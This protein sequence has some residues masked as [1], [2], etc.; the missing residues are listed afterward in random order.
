MPQ[1]RRPPGVAAGT[2]QY[3]QQ[4]AIADHYDDFVADT[5]LCRLDSRLIL[6]LLSKQRSRENNLPGAKEVP[7]TILDLG[8]G[9]GRHSIALAA[10]GFRV[11]A[12]DL[13]QPMLQTL[14]RKLDQQATGVLVHPLR[15][16][17][18]QL[19][20]LAN[21]SADAA[22]CLFSTLGMVQ[23]QP[24]RREVLRHVARTVRAGGLFVLHVHNRWAALREPRGFRRLARSALDAWRTAEGEFG[25]A[26][27]AYRGLDEMFMHRYSRRELVADLRHSGWSI[28]QMHRVSI[29]GSRFETGARICGGFIAVCRRD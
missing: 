20:F 25:D 15:G 8:C 4:R 10:A 9:S 16:N 19:G 22:I 28:Q 29:D 26:V 21:Q 14:R 18:V 12:V 27:Y 13:S 2:W 1:W 24:A 3:V 7:A 6:P 23:T 17:L 11:I 5:P